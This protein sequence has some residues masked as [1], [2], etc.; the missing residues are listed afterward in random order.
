M[1]LPPL[2][3][4]PR[5]SLTLSA[6]RSEVDGWKV[7]ATVA[8]L[9]FA[10]WAVEALNRAAEAA[11]S[12]CL[13]MEEVREVPQG[14]L[15]SLELSH[16][17]S[18]RAAEEPHPLQAMAI[19]G[20]GEK[21]P[22]QTLPEIPEPVLAALDAV[23]RSGLTQRIDCESVAAVARQLGH[24]EAADWIEENP[25]AYA[26]ALFASLREEHR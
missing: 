8:G 20:L 23:R 18:P 26:R 10:E 14:E 4:G 25:T 13:D 16:T 7:A 22:P 19:L 17:E 9:P 15:S 11:I 2:R 6:T 24:E 21:N 1:P 5:E 3:L 12:A